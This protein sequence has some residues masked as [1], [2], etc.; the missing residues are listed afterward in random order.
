MTHGIEAT[1]AS[2]NGIEAK[3]ASPRWRPNPEIDWHCDR[4]PLDMIN[5]A[6]RNHVIRQHSPSSNTIILYSSGCQCSCLA[7]VHSKASM[8]SDK[9]MVETCVVLLYLSL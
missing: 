6:E 5:P 1:C 8:T 2:T 7:I 3:C 4:Y 9:R